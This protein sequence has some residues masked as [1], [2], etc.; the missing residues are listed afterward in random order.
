[1]NWISVPA[2][3]VEEGLRKNS[4]ML[5]IKTTKSEVICLLAM[6]GLSEIL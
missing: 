2:L 3:P 5:K 6:Y 1:M 4:E